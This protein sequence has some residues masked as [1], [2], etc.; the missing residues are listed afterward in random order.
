MQEI[1]K[2]TILGAARNGNLITM[3]SL[4]TAGANVNG[5]NRNGTTALMIA[6]MYGNHRAIDLLVSSGADVN[7]SNVDGTTALMF[8]VRGRSVPSIRSLLEAGAD[9]NARDRQGA[10]ALDQVEGKG[11]GYARSVLL[12]VGGKE[13]NV[14]LETRELS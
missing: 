3:S 7:A 13:R 6:A 8:A 10:T 14:V 2:L 9:V 4:I 5:K 1:P 11:S 12:S